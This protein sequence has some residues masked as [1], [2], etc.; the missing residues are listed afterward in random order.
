MYC[1]L[2]PD[3]TIWQEYFRQGVLPN[4]TAVFK[5]LKFFLH[6]SNPKS[7]IFSQV[8][9]TNLDILDF[10]KFLLNQHIIMTLEEC[11]HWILS[12]QPKTYEGFVPTA[13]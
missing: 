11:Y 10:A 6:F 1:A 9:V 3:F 7:S 12:A 8:P 13:Q 5:I 2:R 4:T